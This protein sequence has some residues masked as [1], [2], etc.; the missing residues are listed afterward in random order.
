VE[1]QVVR[2]GSRITGLTYSPGGT[3]LGNLAY[4]YDADG[5][6]IATAGSL[7][8]VTLL[9]NV[10]GGTNTA[11][12]AANE[13]TSFSG[14]THSY[15]ADGHLISDGS[16]TYTWDVRRVCASRTHLSRTLGFLYW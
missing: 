9:V 12:N 11:Y 8:A 1:K 2:R 16:S 3:N 10:A 14:T 7:A 6:R 15:D 13:Q 5:E 4:T